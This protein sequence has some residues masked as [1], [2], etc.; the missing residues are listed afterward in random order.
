MSISWNRKLTC[1]RRTTCQLRKPRF[2]NKSFKKESQVFRFGLWPPQNIWILVQNL[3]LCCVSAF[4]N[5][6]SEY[7][8]FFGTLP[9]HILQLVPYCLRS[10]CLRRVIFWVGE[11][12]GLKRRQNHKVALRDPGQRALEVKNGRLKIG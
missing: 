12:V 11:K 6:T 10:F 9:S 5:N 1:F 8:D 4:S 7:I 3:F 2:N